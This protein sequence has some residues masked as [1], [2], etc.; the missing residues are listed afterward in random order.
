MYKNLLKNLYAKHKRISI[1]YFIIFALTALNVILSIVPNADYFDFAFVP[2]L[3]VSVETWICVF[4]SILILLAFLL[5][6][7]QVFIADKLFAISFV[8]FAIIYFIACFTVFFSLIVDFS[9][10]ALFRLLSLIAFTTIMLFLSIE[11]FSG[12]K[13]EI[14][15]A[16]L[17]LGIL[18]V[19]VVIF[20]LTIISF[21]QN[22]SFLSLLSFVIEMGCT[23]CFFLSFFFHFQNSLEKKQ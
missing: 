7:K 13:K 12:F 23:I 14:R 21:C 18:A 17:L 6:N 19:F 20:V 11:G 16:Y 5:E 10:L 4:S 9:V 3:P 15:L 2:L 1:C 22:F 8:L